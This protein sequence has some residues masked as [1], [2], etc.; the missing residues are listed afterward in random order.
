MEPDHSATLMDL[1]LRY[2][3]AVVVCNE[4]S[5]RMIR[6]FFEGA[7]IKFQLVKEGET[8]DRAAQAALFH[9]AHGAL[10]GGH[11]QL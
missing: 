1:L 10:A 5:E 3:E 9:G 2:P 8:L 6:Q 11:G 4:K 7:E